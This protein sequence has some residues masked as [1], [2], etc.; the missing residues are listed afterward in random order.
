M[1]TATST[2]QRQ[3]FI[4]Y[5]R[6]KTTMSESKAIYL[7]KVKF[8]NISN[9]LYKIWE[10]E[11]VSR[12]ELVQLTGLTSGTITNLTHELITYG[13]IK[14]SEAVSESVGRKRVNLRFD[15]SRYFIIALDIS[16]TSI[17]AALS[18]LSGHIIE[19]VEYSTEEMDDPEEVLALV[20]PFVHKLLKQVVLDNHSIIGIG[21]SIPGPMDLAAGKLQ[22]PPNF[23]NWAHYPIRSV[24]EKKFGR[25]VIIEDDSRTSALAERWLGISKDGKKDKNIVFVSM[26][27]G[28]GG[29]IIHNGHVLRGTNGLYG[30]IGQMSLMLDAPAAGISPNHG[31]WEDLA[32]IP[33]ILRRWG[34]E[35]DITVFMEEVGEKKPAAV[36][37]WEDTLRMLEAALVTLYNVYDPDVLVLGG[38]L[39]PY[40]VPYMDAV[41]ES[42][43][44]RVHE[45]MVD[46]IRI[47]PSSYGNEQTLVGAAALVL[48]N[49]L[50][51]PQWILE[52]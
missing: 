21:V 47:E 49:L 28:I 8:N 34:N 37:V 44:A 3:W 33:G 46:R 20:E 7:Q 35:G 27:M 51:H 52:G 15:N 18:D 43:K 50:D 19:K 4:L 23:G 17:G 24:L 48:G 5:I 2:L 42:V 12:I 6:V 39:Y 9:V 26:G 32:S 13:L 30:Q 41:T 45:F 36:K 25:R 16:R 14:E 40:I 1:K 29:G 31:C 10:N 38:K 22:S 11:A